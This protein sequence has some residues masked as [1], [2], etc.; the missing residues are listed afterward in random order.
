MKVA[1]VTGAGR[2]LGRVTAEKLARKGF[3][4]LVTDID[5]AAAEATA[6]AIGGDAWWLRQDVRDAGSHREVAK[7]AHERGELALWVNNAGVL[8]AAATWEQSDEDVALQVEVNVLGV[9][10]GSRAAV[11]VMR[12]EGGGHII[13][14][15]SVSA[16]LPTPGLA[17][18]A[19]SKCAVL[20]F[21]L[22]LHGDLEWEKLPIRVSA[23]C[24]DAIDNDMVREVAG[25]KEAALQ[26]LASRL[27]T[28]E[29]VA[30][31]VVGLV[32][33]P[34]LV[35]IHPPARGFLLQALRPFPGLE[36][37][38]LERL[39]RLGDWNRLRRVAAPGRK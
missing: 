27:L 3:A 16:M 30:E 36:L 26:F 34:R 15:A 2:G 6:R 35:T 12:R 17:V 28:P 38:L 20:G 32:D 14:I 9:M 21:S 25:K 31:V 19:A 5:G 29:A 10:H 13:N 11:D 1:V 39:R 4:V 7:A 23:V 8:R 37:R 22:S 24:P 18:Y 33:N